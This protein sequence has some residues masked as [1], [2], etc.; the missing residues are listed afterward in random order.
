MGDKSVNSVSDIDVTI[1]TGVLNR[2]SKKKTLV[3]VVP[4]RRT[5]VSSSSGCGLE[6]DGYGELPR[7][8]S[9][10]VSVGEHVSFEIG[11]ALD[12]CAR[13]ARVESQPQ[14][15]LASATAPRTRVAF[16]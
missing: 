9:V 6:L 8:C 7:G 11:Y 15:E 14:Q 5:G 3:G 10:N 1:G 13:Q 2:A 16:H 4:T 12:G